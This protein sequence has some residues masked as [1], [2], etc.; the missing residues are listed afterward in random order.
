VGINAGEKIRPVSARSAINVSHGR[1]RSACSRAVELSHLQDV[2]QS[3]AA[4]E[5]IVELRYAD[6]ASSRVLCGDGKKRGWLW[7]GAYV[8]RSTSLISADVAAGLNP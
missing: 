3:I 7:I 4:Q 1:P 6:N 5:L 8:P 2:G